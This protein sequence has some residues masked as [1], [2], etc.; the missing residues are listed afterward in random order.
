MTS[1]LRLRH[2]LVP[3]LH[4]MNHRASSE[5]LPLVLPMYYRFPESAEAYQVPNQYQFGSQLLVAA[6]TEPADRHTRLA[7]V[8]AWLPEGTWIDV[9][10]GLVYDGG[11]EIHLHRDLTSIPV[12]AAAGASSRWTVP[13][14]PATS[15]LIRSIWKWWLSWVPMGIST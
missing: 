2:R 9:L 3:Y 6:I 13:R 12:L 14:C 1:F 5:G 7:S 10:D 8:K 11:R 15:R 4:T